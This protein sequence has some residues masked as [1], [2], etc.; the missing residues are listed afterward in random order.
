MGPVSTATNTLYDN[1]SSSNTS[2]KTTGSAGIPKLVQLLKTPVAGAAGVQL[3]NSFT[4]GLGEF[5]ADITPYVLANF[6]LQVSTDATPY[7]MNQCISDITAAGAAKVSVQP[8]GEFSCYV[9]PQLPA[10]TPASTSE[11]AAKVTN[12]GVANAS[13]KALTILHQ[14]K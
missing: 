13:A 11:H 3:T 5:S 4:E 9:V 12:A 10:P 8:L 1:K 2:S 7:L 6:N 14:Q